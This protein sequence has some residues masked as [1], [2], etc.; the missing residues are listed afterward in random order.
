MSLLKL[1]LHT[2][3]RSGPRP[4]QKIP[5]KA[6]HVYLQKLFSFDVIDILRSAILGAITTPPNFLWQNFLE[7]KFPSKKEIVQEESKKSDLIENEEGRLSK[8]NTVA[9]F[10]LD[11]TIGCWLNTLAFLLLFG[12]LKGKGVLEI[13]NEVRG[14][15]NSPRLYE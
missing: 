14:V 13:E 1:S 5:G 12:F 11:Q 2:I 6:D 8:T 4:Y 9:K 3:H 7:K 15:R 10:F